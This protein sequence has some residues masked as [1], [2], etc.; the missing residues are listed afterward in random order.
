[1]EKNI[2][3]KFI[4]ILAII[5]LV[6]LLA[7]SVTKLME[8]NKEAKNYLTQDNVNLKDIE[9][10]DKES[11]PQPEETEYEKASKFFSEDIDFDTYRNKHNNPEIVARLEIPN[12]FNILVTQS[13]DN[14]FYLNKG[15][16]KKKDVKGTEFMDYRVT[17]TSKQ[18]NIYGHNSRTYDIPFRKLEKFLDQDYF[19]NNPYILLQHDGGKRI[20]KIISIKETKDNEHMYVT[21]TPENHVEHIRLLVENSIYQREYQYNQLTNI[22]VLQTC[23]YNDDK[24]YYIITAVEV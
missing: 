15:I 6:L 11:K 1:M 9:N 5:F 22:L 21:S 10:N 20:Y 8:S 12:L 7:F 19:N 3:K 14:K 4:Y 23:S 24:T 17:P 18:V 2:V 16:D 13:K